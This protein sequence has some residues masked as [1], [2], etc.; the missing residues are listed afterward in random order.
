MKSFAIQ[1]HIFNSEHVISIKWRIQLNSQGQS[2]G[3]ID[4]ATIN[5]QLHSFDLSPCDT[6]AEAK[7][8]IDKAMTDLHKMV[9]NITTNVYL[10]GSLRT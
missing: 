3:V 1:N 7:S 4:V 5:N 10:E 2:Y 8:Q 6:R 9:Y